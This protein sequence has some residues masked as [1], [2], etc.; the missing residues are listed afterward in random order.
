MHTILFFT[1]NE[2]STLQQAGG[3]AKTDGTVDQWSVTE[4]QLQE[5][6]NGNLDK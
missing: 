1:S 5:A 4:I 3:Q 6:L 2:I